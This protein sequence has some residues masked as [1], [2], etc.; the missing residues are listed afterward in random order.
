MDLSNTQLYLGLDS[1][2]D[3][4]SQK[5]INFLNRKEVYKHK[6]TIKFEHIIFCIFIL[7]SANV[8]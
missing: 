5:D 8:L 7:Q 1:A 4:V 3:L 6:L 2:Y